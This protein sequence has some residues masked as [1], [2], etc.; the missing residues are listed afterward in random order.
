MTGMRALFNEGKLG[1]IQAVG[2]P[3]QNRSHFRSTDIWTSA[4][5]SNRTLTTG[6]LSRYLSED[7]PEFPAGYPNPAN[8][9]PLAVTMGTVASQTC[10]GLTTN[11]GITVKDP[12]NYLRITPG[13]D[14]PLPDGTKFKNEVDYIRNLISQ[15]NGYGEVVQAAA[16]AAA[17]RTVPSSYTN[18]KLSGQLREVANLISGGLGTS[19]YVATLTGFDTHSG[20]VSSVDAAS[21]TH[22]DLMAELSD[23][24]AAFMED[25]EL[26]G[27]AH[28]V[29]GLTFSEFGRRI[30]E[31][32]SYGTDHGDA[33]PLFAFGNCVQG[34]IL[35]TNPEIDLEVSQGTGVPFQYDFRDVYG[36]VLVDWFDVSPTA[37]TNLVAPGF[38]YL[39][40]FSGC[41]QDLPVDLMSITAT[42]LEK[43]IDVEWAT[44]RESDNAGFVVERSTD[45]RNFH[46]I[47]RVA[48]GA[49][50]TGVNSYIFTDDDVRVGPI[51]YYRLRQENND[52]SFDYS[53]I[54]TAR[55]RGSARGEW[56]V[57]LPRPNPVRDDSYLKVYAPTDGLATFEIFDIIGT[58]VRTGK[59]V[60]T[61]GVDNRVALRPRGLAAGTYA[62]RIRTAD[63]QQFSRK[64]IKQ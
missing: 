62:Y 18:G 14:T 21:G 30:R 38:Q 16:V 44:S 57:G 35:G 26:L 54:Q 5:G 32:A 39:P 43:S 46:R 49:Q 59:L 11:M 42:G 28:R 8:P 63:G 60:L 37:V 22:A 50:G 41:S 4:S 20:Q 3:N 10:Q 9:H 55:L 52:G 15:S 1:A 56:S 45:G 25:L 34:G 33:A 36:S 40:L 31:N 27:V 12:L 58:R 13:G 29:L 48:A 53:P 47:G 23:S 17:D 19:I 51:Y 6:W 7:H 64:F 2:Y 61:G 24:I